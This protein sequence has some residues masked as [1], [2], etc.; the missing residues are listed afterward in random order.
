MG[1]RDQGLGT[2]EKNKEQ[3]AGSKGRYKAYY[4][5]LLIAHCSFS[6]PQSPV[7]SPQSLL[8]Y[9][10]LAT[11][12]L[13]LS[14]SNATG[15]LLIIEANFLS[16]QGRFTEAVA[17]Y[18]KA[19]E[20]E[21]AA[22]YAEYGLGSVYFAMGEEEAALD[23]FAKAGNMLDKLP[24]NLNR[25]LRYRVY[26]NTGVAQFSGGNFSGAADSFR[27]ALKTEGRKTEAKR[28]LELSLLS[29]ARQNTVS[30]AQ[31]ESEGISAL[32]DYIRQKELAQWTKREWQPEEDNAELDY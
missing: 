10:L 11:C 24:P 18:T 6:K 19:L 25:E 22:P 17:Q 31:R 26:Y 21:D 32:F 12:Y 5:A 30:G 20:Y 4:P 2:R 16:S 9:L 29:T 28:N 1:T 15:K 7:P 8:C 23:S 27:D 14:C 13:F 3:V